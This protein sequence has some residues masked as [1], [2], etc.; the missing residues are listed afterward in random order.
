MECFT[1][2]E[3]MADKIKMVEK[4][5]EIISQTNQRMRSL[6]AKIEDLDEWRSM[7]KNVSSILWVIKSYDISVHTLATT[8]CQDLASR[9]EENVRQN[10]TGMMELYEKSI[11]YIQRYIQWLEINLKDEHHVPFSFFQN[12][13]DSYEKIK[14]KVQA[15]E[16]ISKEDIQELLVKPSMEYSHYTDFLHKFVISM[17]EFKK[18]NLAL[19]VKKDHIFNCWEEK[20]LTQHEDW[21]KHFKKKWG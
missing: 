20:I 13:E 4:Y 2:I 17:E 18:C 15:K 5:I 11:Y 9:F 6:Q 19:D 12:L 16:V 21:S 3:K 8:K 14:A 1:V 10:L 7:E